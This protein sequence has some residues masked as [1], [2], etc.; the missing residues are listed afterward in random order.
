[1]SRLGEVAGRVLDVIRGAEGQAVGG[2]FW[3]LLMRT[4]VSGVS[5]FQVVQHE[6]DAIE[7]RVTPVGAL[8]QE[9]RRKVTETVRSAL[10]RGMQVA[11]SEH[12]ALEPLASGKHRFIVSRLSGGTDG[13]VGGGEG[14]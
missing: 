10:G 12:A 8:N 7:I 9:A 14:A 11:F 6:L 4:G 13:Q 3:S 1:M 5:S 2:T